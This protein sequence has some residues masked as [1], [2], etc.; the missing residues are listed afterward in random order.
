MNE[1][2]N[3]TTIAPFLA[4]EFI[5]SEE[6]SFDIEDYSKSLNVLKKELGLFSN[7]LICKLH[8]SWVLDMK[9]DENQFS[10]SLNDFTTFVFAEAIIE[11]FELDI[12]PDSF[13]FPLLLEFKGN[14]SVTY[15]K[16]DENGILHTTQPTKLDVYLY[17]QV[18][19][20][21]N[22]RIE[23]V[24]NLWKSDPENGG[25]NIILIVVANE[26][27]V[28]EKQLE[29][30]FEIFGNKYD[31]YYNYFREQF[32]SGRFVSDQHICLEL[33]EELIKKSTTR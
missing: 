1:L 12:D 11:K 22:G 33:I 32:I 26:I 13:I 2:K 14:P 31:R 21:E 23:I 20:L 7:Y 5:E 25:E 24:F 29:T 28:T 6:E 16:V 15:Y 30:W 18:K 10:I 27:I 19:F 17:E 4:D 9:L 3:I 8:D